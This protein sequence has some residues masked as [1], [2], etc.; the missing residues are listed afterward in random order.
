MRLGYRRKLLLLAHRTLRAV[1]I[2]NMK[3]YVEAEEKL[4]SFLSSGP[5]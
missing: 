1:P 4:L 2:H 3:A 5:D